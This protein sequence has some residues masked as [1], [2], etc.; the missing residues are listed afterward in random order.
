MAAEENEMLFQIG[1]EHNLQFDAY[2][3]GEMTARDAVGLARYCIDRVATPDE[4]RIYRA[5][6]SDQDTLTEC[7][8]L[9]A[10]ARKR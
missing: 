4:I 8:I 7:P 9:D 1:R 10:V 6:R 3:S 5:R 2:Y